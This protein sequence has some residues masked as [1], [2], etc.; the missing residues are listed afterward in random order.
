[1]KSFFLKEFDRQA[2]VSV[3]E[4]FDEIDSALYEGNTHG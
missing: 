1:M 3:K 2:S 4:M